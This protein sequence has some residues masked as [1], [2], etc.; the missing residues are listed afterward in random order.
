MICPEWIDQ[1][2]SIHTY[3]KPT[4]KRYSTLCHLIALRPSFRGEDFGLRG[5]IIIIYFHP[6]QSE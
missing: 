6:T 1:I 2:L 5:I 4:S 3:V